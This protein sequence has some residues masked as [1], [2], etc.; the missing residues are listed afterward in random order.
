MKEKLTPAEVKR[1]LDD[2]AKDRAIHIGIIPD[3][4]D[5]I[6]TGTYTLWINGC[7]VE[8][9]SALSLIQCLVEI[10]GSKALEK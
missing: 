4:I 7:F 9:G 6:S 10:I 1:I 3:R 2:I 8:G 5:D